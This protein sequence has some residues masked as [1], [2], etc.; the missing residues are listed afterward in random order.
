MHITDLLLKYRRPL[1]DKEAE[2]GS[3]GVGE[4]GEV[5]EG[6]TKETGENT[7]GDA[8]G[9]IAGGL[10]DRRKSDEKS[11]DGPPIK[12]KETHDDG[13]PEGISDKFWDAEKKAVRTDALVKSYAE[14]EAAH[15]KLKREKS[16]G[17]E[18]PE[19]AED[20][21]RDGLDLGDDVDRLTVDGPDD[22]GL[23]AWG[24]IC[25]KYGI[26]KELA[27]NLAR[28]MFGEMNEFAP[29]PIDPD[30]EYEALGKGADAIIDGVFTW[31]DGAER[32]GKLTDGDV[33][34]IN[35][36]QRTAKG[37][38]FL[39]SMRAMAG[40]DRIP[41]IPST[42][43][44]G[45]TA[46]QWHEEMKDAVKAKDFKRQAELDEMSVG[47]FGDAPSHGG[48]PGGVNAEKQLTRGE[49]RG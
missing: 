20:Y 28:D 4:G 29:A 15:G 19:K 12:Q 41:I 38:S 43:K 6:E 26:G 24:K 46:D 5:T 18:V 35:D 11:D 8:K 49:R 21:F 3:G 47:I 40:E 25:H 14:L 42:G 22:P 32:S 30:Q 31:V 45:L 37:I 48:R 10:L 17:G 7:E 27:V 39:A 44:R 34:I 36:L 2:G 9:K 33:E 1:F 23:K 16:V 13:R